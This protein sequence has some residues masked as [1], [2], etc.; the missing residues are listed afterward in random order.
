MG[1]DNTQVEL[2]CEACGGDAH[3]SERTGRS[4]KIVLCNH[5][6]ESLKSEQV[7]NYQLKNSVGKKIRTGISI[8]EFRDNNLGATL[9][10][11]VLLIG[12]RYGRRAKPYKAYDHEFDFGAQVN[13]KFHGQKRIVRRFM[14]CRLLALYLPDYTVTNADS[15]VLFGMGQ[16]YLPVLRFGR[17]RGQLTPNTI[18]ML[19][20]K[21]NWGTGL[22]R[23]VHERDRPELGLFPPKISGCN[24]DAENKIQGFLRHTV[25]L[26][27]SAINSITWLVENPAGDGINNWERHAQP[28]FEMFGANILSWRSGGRQRLSK[29]QSTMSF[30]KRN[31]RIGVLEYR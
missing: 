3:H 15:I 1:D 29:F 13:T 8:N 18:A 14:L 4:P 30:L 19:L 25:K 16:Y 10:R 2:Y 31:I 22:A 24:Q 6:L 7:Q 28:L 5:W 27:R 9:A 26:G 12:F 11:E 17:L 21:N 20:K 23:P